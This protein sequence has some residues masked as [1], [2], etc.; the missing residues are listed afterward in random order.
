MLSTTEHW[1]V[2]QAVETSGHE[3]YTVQGSGEL[4]LPNEIDSEETYPTGQ[5]AVP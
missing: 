5:Q 4:L 1:D 2:L 3:W